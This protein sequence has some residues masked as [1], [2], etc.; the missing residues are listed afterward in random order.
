MRED[1]IEPRE[2]VPDP[3]IA[4][5]NQQEQ[6]SDGF[7]MAIAAAAGC[8]LSRPVP[9]N[10]SIDWT[11]SCRLPRRP[12][13]DIQLKSTIFQTGAIGDIRYRLNM[14]NYNDLIL[15]DLVVPRILLLVVV[16]RRLEEWLSMTPESLLL[17]YTAYWRCLSGEPRLRN[18][19]NCT[20]TIPQRNLLTPAALREMMLR[21]NDGEPL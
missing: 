18:T 2:S 20:V 13:L 7:L 4:R 17:R 12:K 8:A 15:A 1:L 6:F 11:L 19:R 9:D 14:K 10:D 21:I 3:W 5:P 16:P